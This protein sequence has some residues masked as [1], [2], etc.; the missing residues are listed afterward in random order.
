MRLKQHFAIALALDLIITDMMVAFLRIELLFC[1]YFVNGS[2]WQEASLLSVVVGLPG[3][4][5]LL[6]HTAADGMRTLNVDLN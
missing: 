6:D 2:Q 3:I 5:L 4:M 1:D